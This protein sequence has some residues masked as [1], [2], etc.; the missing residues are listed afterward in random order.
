[1]QVYLNFLLSQ[2]KNFFALNYYDDIPSSVYTFA[3]IF[4]STNSF[5][6]NRIVNNE[7]S[8]EKLANDILKQ[9]S[10]GNNFDIQDFYL[11]NVGSKSLLWSSIFKY[12]NI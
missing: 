9:F 6:I 4:P 1:M 5:L 7:K 10:I 3:Q 12:R 8:K 11:Q 2:F